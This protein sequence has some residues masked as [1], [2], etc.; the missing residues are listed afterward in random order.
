MTGVLTFLLQ[1][2]RSQISPSSDEHDDTYPAGNKRIGLAWYDI[3]TNIT[4][5]QMLRISRLLVPLL[6]LLVRCSNGEILVDNYLPTTFLG[7]YACALLFFI[8]YIGNILANGSRHGKK[9]SEDATRLFG[10]A[11]IIRFVKS[12]YIVLLLLLVAGVAR[13]CLQFLF[14]RFRQCLVPGIEGLVPLVYTFGNNRWRKGNL[15][16][17]DTQAFS[18]VFRPPYGLDS[19]RDRR[20]AALLAFSVWIGSSMFVYPRSTVICEAS[21]ASRIVILQGLVVAIDICILICAHQCIE[22]IRVA[23]VSS[24]SGTSAVFGAMCFVSILFC[25]LINTD[26]GR[27]MLLWS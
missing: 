20:I 24:I 7:L 3:S 22:G 26:G 5:L 17:E 14:I 13:I 18:G 10:T 12:H 16:V 27:H 19:A 21:L 11:F 15:S 6:F 9:P 25:G 8:V 2:H 4:I 1:D 23:S